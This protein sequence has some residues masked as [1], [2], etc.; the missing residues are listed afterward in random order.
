VITLRWVAE[1]AAMQVLACLPARG[2]VLS[3]ALY[4]PSNFIFQT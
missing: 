2:L 3:M 1:C 4:L